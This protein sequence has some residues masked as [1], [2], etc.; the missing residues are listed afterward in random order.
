MRAH[1]DPDLAFDATPL[2][3]RK[4]RLHIP[5]QLLEDFL[6][7]Q[8]TAEAASTLMAVHAK[9]LLSEGSDYTMA[10]LELAKQGMVGKAGAAGADAAWLVLQDV[11]QRPE[12]P[13]GHPRLP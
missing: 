9:E 13:Q 4:G 7:N 3:M 11:H 5:Q 6:D 1:R 8:D 10:R 12:D 2:V